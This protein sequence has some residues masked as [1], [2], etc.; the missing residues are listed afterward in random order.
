MEPLERAIAVASKSLAAKKIDYPIHKVQ[1]IHSILLFLGCRISAAV[2][3]V[4]GDSVLD[5][6]RVLPSREVQRNISCFN[7]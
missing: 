7:F 4:T 3:H 2:F 1:N 6:S 5:Q